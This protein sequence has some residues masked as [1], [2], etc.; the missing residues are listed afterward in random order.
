[1]PGQ[2]GF[3]GPGLRDCRCL[4]VE[5]QCHAG[6]ARLPPAPAG[7]FVLASLNYRAVRHR[8]IGIAQSRKRRL[9]FRLPPPGVDDGRMTG[10]FSHMI[11]SRWRPRMAA[12]LVLLAQAL[13]ANTRLRVRPFDHGI[14]PGLPARFAAV[15]FR[16]CP[17]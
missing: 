15:V 11:P 6:S 9:E 1:M 10:G 3:G 14:N 16:R 13:S 17:M 5:G 2:S 4:P 8:G 12:R 7:R